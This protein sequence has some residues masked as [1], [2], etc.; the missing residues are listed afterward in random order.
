MIEES[1]KSGEVWEVLEEK[2]GFP[3]FP[4]LSRLPWTSLYKFMKKISLLLFLLVVFV[5]SGSAQTAGLS[6]LEKELVDEI[7]RVRTNPAA[8]AKW[9][10]DNMKNLP[11][12]SEEPKA[13]PEAVKVLKSTAPLPAFM[14]VQGVSEAARFQVKDQLPTGD[15]SHQSTD[16]SSIDKRLKRFGKLEGGA[17]ENFTIMKADAKAMVLSWIVDDFVSGRGHRKFILHKSLNQIGVACD[18][19]TK[20]AK[21]QGLTLCVTTFAQKFK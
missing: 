5:F 3:D 14:L 15:F 8:Y 19:Y 18:V 20:S 17:A 9:I 6:P 12:K 11:Y 1:G 13:L 16:G 21:Y 4:G 10:E 7:N 2:I